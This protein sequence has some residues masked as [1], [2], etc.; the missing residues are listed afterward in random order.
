MNRAQK[1]RVQ[2]K[3]GTITMQI[4]ADYPKSYK[5]RYW[6]AGKLI[7]AAE[8]ISKTKIPFRIKQSDGK[9]GN[10]NGK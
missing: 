10:Y 4:I 8:L 6:I 3:A 1:R 5:P 2:Q 9:D 7:R